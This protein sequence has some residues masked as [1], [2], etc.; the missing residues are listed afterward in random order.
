[1]LIRNTDLILFFSPADL[2]HLS[3]LF[4]F[5]VLG[6]SLLPPLMLRICS[7][8]LGCGLHYGRNG[9][10]QNPFSRKGLYPWAACSS[11]WHFMSNEDGLK[12]VTF[13]DLLLFPD[14]YF[15]LFFFLIKYIAAIEILFLGFAWH[16]DLQP[17]TCSSCRSTGSTPSSLTRAATLLL[18]AP[19]LSH[20]RPEIELIVCSAIAEK[21]TA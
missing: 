12:T 7:G 5:I 19:W 15:L 14:F 6:Y 20:K 21:W 3:F 11:V 4:Y 17:P 8:Y 9:S 2:L 10:P 18:R 13:S 1:M 16:L